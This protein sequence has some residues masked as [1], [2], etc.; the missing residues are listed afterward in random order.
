MQRLLILYHLMLKLKGEV[1]LII[2]LPLY[3]FFLSF[4]YL[5]TIWYKWSCFDLL[6]FFSNSYQ[7]KRVSPLTIISFFQCHSHMFYHGG[8]F[9]S[10]CDLNDSLTINPSVRLSIYPSVHPSV[11]PSV[12][13]YDFLLPLSIAPAHSHSTKSVVN[14]AS[15][16]FNCFDDKSCTLVLG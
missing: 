5:L 8:F 10:S 4:F 3:F 13:L 12:I 11:P 14:T 7:D 1:K 2:I 6:V 15:L 9:R 16:F